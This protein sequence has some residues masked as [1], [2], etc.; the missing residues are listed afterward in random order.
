[1]GDKMA[2][3]VTELRKIFVFLDEGL[4]TAF[5]TSRTKAPFVGGG[6]QWDW[7]VCSIA[8]RRLLMAVNLCDYRNT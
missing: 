1:M 2:R 8:G 7:L 4:R 3:Y 6:Q 5:H